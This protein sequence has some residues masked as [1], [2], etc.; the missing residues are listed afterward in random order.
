MYTSRTRIRIFAVS[1][2]ACVLHAHP[3]S[4][5]TGSPNLRF[6]SLVA[7]PPSQQERLVQACR[8][9]SL[10]RS[11][12][13][14]HRRF[15]SYCNSRAI[16]MSVTSRAMRAKCR[17]SH[18]VLTLIENAHAAPSC[19]L[20]TTTA[21]HIIASTFRQ[22]NGDLRHGLI[23]LTASQHTFAPLP[24]VPGEHRLSPSPPP[25][26]PYVISTTRGEHA[27][28]RISPRFLRQQLAAHLPFAAPPPSQ[29]APSTPC[30]Q[31]PARNSH[32]AARPGYI[33]CYLRRWI[34]ISSFLIRRRFR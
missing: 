4:S 19:L 32:S 7:R 26:T 2:R 29:P 6:K 23:L 20:W 17:C 10:V 8:Q 11:S 1:C 21:I 18:L 33:D 25:Q 9:V 24:G 3:P 14:E 27:K 16:V 22:A 15:E 5:Q 12:R 28:G 34:C 31:I 30:T 13:G